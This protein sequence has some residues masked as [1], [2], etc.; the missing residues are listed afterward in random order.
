MMSYKWGAEI[1]KKG[2]DGMANAAIETFKSRD[3]MEGFVRELL[4]NSQDARKNNDEPLRIRLRL[5]SLDKAELPLFKEQWMPI[6]KAIKKK[7]S[8]GYPGFFESA[9][10]VLSREKILVLEY[11][12]FNTSGLSGSDDDHSS[13][14]SACVL[15]EGTSVEKSNDSGGSY[16]IGKNAVYG[17]SGI[18]TVIYS[19]LNDKDEFIFQGVS[20]LASYELG[21]VNYN[22]RIYLGRDNDELS[23]I[24]NAKHIPSVFKRKEC[25]L[26]QFVIGVNLE[27]GWINKVKKII[28][29]NYF[30][31]LNKGQVSFELADTSTGV[32]EQLDSTNF[33]KIAHDSFLT[34]DDS[35]KAM[36]VWPKICALEEKPFI[37]EVRCY[38][39]RLL[40]N[41]FVVHFT[42]DFPFGQNVVS[43][44]RRGMS[45]YQEKLNPAGGIGYLNLVGV[46]YSENETVNSTLRLME[47][48]TH[49][50]WKRDL[51]ADRTIDRDQQK[52]A[53][54][55]EKEIKEF[56]R[57]NAKKFLGAISSE[58]HSII[59]VDELLRIGSKPSTV[60]GFNS[61]RTGE[62]DN[63]RETALK[64]G[65]KY[66]IDLKFSSLHGNLVE[67][68]FIDDPRGEVKK[69]G[70]RN[71]GNREGSD[72]RA[73][74]SPKGLKSI[75]LHGY[76]CI[77]IHE[78]EQE[79]LYQFI[80]NSTHTG[81]A[82]LGISQAGDRNS[83][84]KPDIVDAFQAGRKLEVIQSESDVIIKDVHFQSGNSSLNVR[85]KSLSKAG[86]ILQHIKINN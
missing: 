52:W 84:V 36:H 12:D 56:V 76:K 63:E 45:I 71:G 23:S 81:G 6:F 78:E 17:L 38:D 80:I 44:I 79:R 48:A 46:F 43:Y 73:G 51:L 70:S 13:S 66:E 75:N 72:R 59:E 19:S 14:F 24:R 40:K 35:E 16:G 50:S 58:T 22:S 85:I 69:V 7:W 41:G 53:M 3:I 60:F 67:G 55:L 15:S 26:S 2:I 74:M 57:S 8:K 86:L 61:S 31:L 32:C 4:Q 82:D 39:G 33:K 47:P 30:V 28:I 64:S 34:L 10:K 77:L 18:R 1:K 54:N 83:K 68:E 5:F 9:D 62:E 49:D 37:G 25:G 42:N 21:S 29:D 11:S 27:D 20:K 65:K